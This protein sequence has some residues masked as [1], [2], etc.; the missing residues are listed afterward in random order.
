VSAAVLAKSDIA[1]DQ[2]RS[3]R[4]KFARRQAFPAEKFVHRARAGGGQKHPFRVDPAISLCRAA[5]YEDRARSTH[6]NQF[7]RV[8]RQVVWRQR[9]GIFQEIAGHPVVFVRRGNIFDELAE[10]PPVK[11]RSAHARRTDIADRETR[12]VGHGN[13]GRLAVARMPLDTHMFCVD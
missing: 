8:D 12:I 1:T 9:A 7:V 2:R 3:H 10:M 5:T 13:Q 11:R 4:R 6:G